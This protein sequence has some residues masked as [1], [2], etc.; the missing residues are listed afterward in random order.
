MSKHGCIGAGGT[1]TGPG[2]W[3]SGP[4]CVLAPVTPCR[5]MPWYGPAGA[6]CGRGVWPPVRVRTDRRRCCTTGDPGASAGAEGGGDGRLAGDDGM[7]GEP[8][9]GRCAVLGR[10]TV[11]VTPGRRTAGGRR[12]GPLKDNCIVQNRMP[13]LRV[14]S[15]PFRP[16]C[17]FRGV[18]GA[19][20]AASCTPRQAILVGRTSSGVSSRTKGMGG[21]PRGTAPRR[22]PEAGS[23]RGC[24]VAIG[25]PGGGLR[26]AA[27]VAVPDRPRSEGARH[28][29]PAPCRIVGG[30]LQGGKAVCS[31]GA[32]D[33][34]RREEPFAADHSG[35]ARNSRIGSRRAERRHRQ[36]SWG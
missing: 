14:P 16:G 21:P 19:V 2:S 30:H 26:A 10:A 22:S 8:A 32:A 12:L 29:S 24:V 17:G 11:P 18:H 4:A 15:G 20:A 34:P 1:S 28:R 9:D 7:M 25:H 23:G 31:S 6:P 5:V 35:P 36:G 33:A 3:A 27:Q 13:G